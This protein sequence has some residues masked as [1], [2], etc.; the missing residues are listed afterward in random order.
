[1]LKSYEK[2]I[3]E[4]YGDYTLTDMT[5]IGDS[6]RE[7]EITCRKC[8]AVETRIYVN[9]RNKL[10]E[11]PKRCKR[12]EE[13]AKEEKLVEEKKARNIV[14]QNQIGRVI[15]DYEVVSY[16]DG[17]YTLRCTTCGFKKEII[18]RKIIENTITTT[19]CTKHT[20]IKIKYDESYVGRKNNLLTV[21][22][23]TKDKSRKKAFLCKCDCGKETIV[24]PIFWENG[25]I[26]S[27]GCYQ[28][29]RGI[30][31][32]EIN[33]IKGIYHGMKS[34]CLNP[35]NTDYYNYGGRGIKICD[36]WLED[37]NN[38][39]KWS[40]DNGYDNRLTIDRIDCNGN[41][42]PD[43][44]RWATYKVQNINRRPRGKKWQD[45]QQIKKVVQ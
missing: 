39:I 30:G 35:N 42:E 36:E 13:S 40:L 4:E 17:K 9:G 20:E 14:I 38:F 11:L 34:R 8:G 2:H 3:G 32:D 41:Y 1:M 12:C 31:K 43:N 7:I 37:V 33:R 44:C 5:Y 18:E 15:G 29:N 16:S 24:K 45:Q 22:C 6:E 10:R 25:V 21:L 23:I 27:C 28:E 19:R 26:K